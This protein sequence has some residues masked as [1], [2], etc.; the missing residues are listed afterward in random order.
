MWRRPVVTI[1]ILIAALVLPLPVRAQQKTVAPGLSPARAYVAASLPRHGGVK[2]PLRHADLKVSATTAAATS[3]GVAASPAKPFT[4]EQVEG[5]VR[6]GLGD[7]SGAKLIEQRG[8]DF[9]PSG[10]FIQTLKAAG[11]SEA[12]LNALRA[13]VAPGLSPARAALKGGSTTA[14]PPASAKKPINQVQVLALLAGQVPS[15]LCF[16]SFLSGRTDGVNC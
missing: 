13:A 2:P 11:A 7:D 12:F 5:L 10:D 16:K 6:D 1:L 3:P 8:I 14:G 15:H 4:R 9:A